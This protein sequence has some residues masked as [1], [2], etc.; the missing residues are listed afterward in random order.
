MNVTLIIPTYRNPKYLDLCLKSA[1]EN[2]DSNQNHILVIVDGFLEES[3]SVLDKYPGIRYIDLEVNRGMQYAL[4]IGVM[5]AETEYVF[6]INDDNVLPM[7]WDTRLLDEI[8]T[9]QFR[10]DVPCVNW[11]LT[12]NQ[13]EPVGPSMFDFVIEDFGRTV[14]T[15]AYTGWLSAEQSLS[16]HQLFTPMTGHIFPF[17][18]QKKHYLAVG[19]FDTFYN[20][21]NICD[22]DFFLKL[23]LLDFVFPRTK[24]LHLYHFGS[25]STKKNAESHQFKARE[26][27]AF[28]EYQFKWGTM[29][30]NEPISNSKLPID[31]TFRGFQI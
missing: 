23:E 7:H 9:L 30:H 16:D 20:S 14:D 10:S 28:S 29:P 12:I 6:I 22:W 21:P 4:N 17:A 1:I 18:I 19:G 31:R 11:V 27:Q 3:Q 5:Q 13:V 26:A 2:C 24:A 8:N 15:F 25:V